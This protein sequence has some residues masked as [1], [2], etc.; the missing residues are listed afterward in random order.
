MVVALAQGLY[1]LCLL[2]RPGR[3]LLL[4]GV[5]GNM[6]IVI[7]WLVTRTSRIPLLGPHA[8]DVEEVGALDLFCTLAEVCVVFGLGALAM[9]DLVTESRIQVAVVLAVSALLFWHLLHLLAG[10]SAH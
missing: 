8:G 9:K 5:A 2:R 10:S 3:P 6:T 7:L 4:F 1:A